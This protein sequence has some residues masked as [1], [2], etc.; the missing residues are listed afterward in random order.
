MTSVKWEMVERN[1]FD[2]GKSLLLKENNQRNRYLTEN[3]IT[4]LLDECKS[5]KHLHR[6][7]TC[8]INTGMRRG[9]ILPLKWSQIRNGF[10]YLEKTKTKNKREIPI[11]DDLAVCR[12]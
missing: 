1:P 4:S 9:E 6:I 2:R 3:E 8:A 5:R 11:N 12:P 10:I 7:A